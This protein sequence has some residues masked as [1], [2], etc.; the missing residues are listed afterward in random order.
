[1]RIGI[2]A[3]LCALSQ[4]SFNNSFATNDET[5]LSSLRAHSF[6]YCP[7]PPRA[8][9]CKFSWL[10][11]TTHMSCFFFFRG[12]HSLRCF[13]SHLLS[14]ANSCVSTGLRRLLLSL[15]R[16]D[17]MATPMSFRCFFLSAKFRRKSI[18]MTLTF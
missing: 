14:V 16:C 6:A 12:K 1:M 4:M 8:S 13:V 11:R 9:V 18:D 3:D 7:P 15:A 10:V 2:A 5:Q 17:A